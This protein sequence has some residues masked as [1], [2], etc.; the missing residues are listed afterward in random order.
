MAYSPPNVWLHADNDVDDENL[1]AL[2]DDLEYIHAKSGDVNYIAVTPAR[3]TDSPVF[4]IVHRK[5]YLFYRSTGAIV[6]LTAVE[7]EDSITLSE[8][9][10]KTGVFQRYDLDSIS[11]LAYGTLDQVTGVGWC[12]ED[13]NP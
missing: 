10:V 1:Q 5:R 13:D 8:S 9:S 4:S 3:L 12:E 7:P 6:D 2:S 11:W